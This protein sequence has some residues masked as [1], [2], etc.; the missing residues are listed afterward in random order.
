MR[1]NYT[2]P[3]C[4]WHTVSESP[5]LETCPIPVHDGAPVVI[6][7]HNKT[8]ADYPKCGGDLGEFGPSVMWFDLPE[9]IRAATEEKL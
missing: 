5:D 2:C 1:F 7:S 8:Y 4:S 3:R 6:P 9:S